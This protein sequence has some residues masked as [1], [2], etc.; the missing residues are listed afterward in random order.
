[1]A[2]TTLLLGA[3]A[4]LHY[5]RKKTWGAAALLGLAVALMMHAHPTTLLMATVL[6]L[7]ALFTAPDWRKRLSHLIIVAL[8]SVLPLIPMFAQQVLLGF[9]DFH[10]LTLYSESEISLPSWQR[11]GS[12]LAAIFLYGPAYLVHYWFELPSPLS[13]GLFAA[14]M[15]SLGLTLWGLIKA[16]KQNSQRRVL[17]ALLLA[18]LLG[19][20]FF[21]TLLRP[22]T[23]FWMV[24]AHWPLIAALCA[25]GLDSLYTS[26]N[27]N[28]ILAGLTLLLWFSWSI[29]GFVYIGRAPHE[30]F[31][32]IPPPGNRSLV[33]INDLGLF[34]ERTGVTI[35]RLPVNEMLTIEK[36]LCQPTTLY[37][38]YIYLVDMS[39]GFG[40]LFHCRETQQIVLGGPGD[41]NAAWIGM[42]DYAWNQAG[43]VPQ[44]W[45]GLLGVTVPEKVW[46]DSPSLSIGNIHGV[47]HPTDFAL[48]E[49]TVSAEV[50][51]DR[52]LLIGKR[53]GH[54]E[55]RKATANDQEVQAAY[56]DIFG[57][58]LFK[59]PTVLATDE[60]IRWTFVL[61]GDPRYID[62]VSFK[63]GGRD[64]ESKH[65][66]S[67]SLRG[68]K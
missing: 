64:Q 17:V 23:P 3:L 4:A 9:P 60:K 44:Q 2:E 54:F 14:L 33:N 35:A 42:R 22:I 61:Y 55:L 15:V 12:V 39:F 57:F 59:T 53:W 66:E 19:Q 65:Q 58:S 29:A 16:V 40:A 51:P 1:M 18:A 7:L 6:V 20:T 32:H 43:I 30:V 25:L 56:Q 13:H 31:I 34:N 8:F 50:P 36:P 21:V 49:F 52:A 11:I 26:D 45:L 68:A 63:A 10:A 46:S 5:A 24:Y 48:K 28:R 27:R 62:V 37:G 38:H 67:S 47:K 41:T